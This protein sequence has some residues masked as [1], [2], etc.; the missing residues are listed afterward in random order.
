MTAEDEIE[1][2]ADVQRLLLPDN[3]RIRGL[4]YSV[5]YQPAAIAAGDYYDLMT[6]NGDLPVAQSSAPVVD[7]WGV[8]LGDVSGH[9]PAAAME[10]VQFDAILR[11][12]RDDEAPGGPAGALTYA[13]RYFFSRRPRRHFMTVFAALG[14]PHEDA[15][16]YVSAGHPPA[17]LRRGD[18]LS[19]LGE[20]GD[21]P[22][23]INREQRYRNSTTSFLPGDLLVVTTDGI[24][25]ATNR[26][27]EPFGAPRIEAIVSTVAPHPDAILDALR[28]AV[29]EHQGVAIGNDD[30]TILVLLRTD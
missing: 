14:R 20:D 6:L 25:E 1:S 2:L 17:L 9:G 4:T 3:P 21:I 16:D 27:G 13:N 22:L 5:H 11:T 19:R 29:I 8:M 7:T 24:A 18:R 26:R 23:G 30:Q 28:D 15:L 10:A 12:Y